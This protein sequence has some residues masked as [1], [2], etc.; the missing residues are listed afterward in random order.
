MKQQDVEECV[1]SVLQALDSEA[2]D[3]ISLAF[4]DVDSTKVVFVYI[5]VD[6]PWRLRYKL[7]L[8]V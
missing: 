5:M 1:V 4:P 8:V 6:E 2:R 3:L 7:V